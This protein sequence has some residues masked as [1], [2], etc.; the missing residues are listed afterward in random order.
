MYWLF[1][2][3]FGCVCQVGREKKME[4]ENGGGKIRYSPVIGIYT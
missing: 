4:E 1:G 2:I 3:I